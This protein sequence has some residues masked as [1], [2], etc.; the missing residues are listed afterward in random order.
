[1]YIEYCKV[2]FGVY[3][4]LINFVVLFELGRNLLYYKIIKVLLNYWF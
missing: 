3:R 2:I 1:M 4:K